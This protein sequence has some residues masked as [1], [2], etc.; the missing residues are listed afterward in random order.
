L[1][2]RAARGALEEI[3]RQESALAKTMTTKELAEYLRV[4]EITIYKHAAAAEIP[5]LKTE[6]F[7]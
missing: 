4:H 6:T 5:G 1:S 7:S 3:R 2:I